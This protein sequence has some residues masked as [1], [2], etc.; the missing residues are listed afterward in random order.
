MV[1]IFLWS[2]F[3]GKIFTIQHLH[4]TDGFLS[5]LRKKSSGEKCRKHGVAEPYYEVR[6]CGIAIGFGRQLETNHENVE[7]MREKEE[8]IITVLSKA[9]KTTINEVVEITGISHHRIKDMLKRM[10]QSGKIRRVS[11]KRSPETG[12]P[13]REAMRSLSH[14]KRGW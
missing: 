14:G 13:E 1:K 11:H 9:P 12:L 8:L 6:P 10:K 4:R 7:Q 5:L 3:P 2:K